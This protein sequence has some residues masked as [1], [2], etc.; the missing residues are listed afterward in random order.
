MWNFLKQGTLNALIS[1]AISM[2]CTVQS[3]VIPNHSDFSIL[4]SVF[5]NRVSNIDLQTE[6]P[7]F[8]TFTTEEVLN[9]NRISCGLFTVV[10]YC[11]HQLSQ[12]KTGKIYSIFSQKKSSKAIK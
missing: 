4:R 6:R 1:F 11:I 2:T 5:L 12:Q 10:F 7:F 3:P 8:Q 9:G